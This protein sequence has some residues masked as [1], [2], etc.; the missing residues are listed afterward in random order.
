MALE[1]HDAGSPIPEEQ[2]P[3]FAEHCLRHGVQAV[4]VTLDQR[5][6]VAYHLDDSGGLVEEE[7][8]RIV[9]EHV[10]D[11]TGAGDSFAA[12]MAFG[13]LQDHDIVSAPPVRQRHGCAAG[14]RLGPRRL[15]PAGGDQQADRPHLRALR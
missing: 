5:G 11:A 14:Q 12:G 15:P 9:V 13:F 10:V 6:C 8:P 2:L 3:D 1:H 4:C 7:I